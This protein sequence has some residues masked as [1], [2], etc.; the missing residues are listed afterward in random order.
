MKYISKNL[1]E[2]FTIQ[3]LQAILRMF[4]FSKSNLYLKNILEV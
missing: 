4:T 3:K 1:E 2:I